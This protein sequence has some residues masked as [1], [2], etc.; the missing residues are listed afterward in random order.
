MENARII[1]PTDAPF[2]SQFF[3]RPPP[4]FRKKIF[5]Q[6]NG[7]SRSQV[8]RSQVT[9]FGR[10]FGKKKFAKRGRAR[11]KN[12]RMKTAPFGEIFWAFLGGHLAGKR[13]R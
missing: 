2:V 8:S 11:R 6:K 12:W 7:Q 3:L 4:F 9:G 5:F 10:F 13:L 1:M